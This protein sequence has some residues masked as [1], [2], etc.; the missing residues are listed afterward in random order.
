MVKNKAEFFQWKQFSEEY[1]QK[2]LNWENYTSNSNHNN[3]TIFLTIGTSLILIRELITYLL[4]RKK[5]KIN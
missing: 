3:L 1:N 2:E 5:Q 4:T